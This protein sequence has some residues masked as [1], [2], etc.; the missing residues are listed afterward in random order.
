MSP[1]NGTVVCGSSLATNPAQTMH[2]LAV[3]AATASGVR[4]KTSAGVR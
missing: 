1:V 4:K 2:A 3:E